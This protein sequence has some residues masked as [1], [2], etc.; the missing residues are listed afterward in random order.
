MIDPM[1]RKVTTSV[2]ITVRNQLWIEEQKQKYPNF[3]FTK[4]VNHCI[5]KRRDKNEPNKGDKT[6]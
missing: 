3:T 2:S 5:E 1:E 4:F 6:T